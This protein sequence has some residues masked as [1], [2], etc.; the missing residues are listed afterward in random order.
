MRVQMK[1]MNGFV[2]EGCARLGLSCAKMARLWS[3]RRQIRTNRIGYMRSRDHDIMMMI[4]IMSAGACSP[5]CH[6]SCSQSLSR[7]RG[8]CGR[9]QRMPAS[10]SV[11]LTSQTCAN[12]FHLQKLN[13]LCVPNPGAWATRS[14]PKRA[15]VVLITILTWKA[16]CGTWTEMVITGREVVGAARVLGRSCGKSLSLTGSGLSSKWS[17]TRSKKLACKRS[18]VKNSPRVGRKDLIPCSLQRVIWRRC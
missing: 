5:I 16:R 18:M 6:R 15:R 7:R 8:V 4:M 14:W 3:G 12:F 10:G 11:S 2:A 17:K 1:N 9:T 13:R